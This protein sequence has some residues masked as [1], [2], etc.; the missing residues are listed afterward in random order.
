MK[1]ARC[2]FKS[3]PRKNLYY[4]TIASEM[5]V[6]VSAVDFAHIYLDRDIWTVNVNHV[7]S[8]NDIPVIIL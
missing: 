3:S 2:G 6:L 8:T 4:I 5:F 1:G 7:P